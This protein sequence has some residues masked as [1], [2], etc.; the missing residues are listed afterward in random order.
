LP[1]YPPSIPDSNETK[2]ASISLQVALI[3]SFVTLTCVIVMAALAFPYILKIYR[4]S[5]NW[6][7]D[8]QSKRSSKRSEK[9][10][11]LKSVI[12]SSAST[13]ATSPTSSET[14]FHFPIIA[15]PPVSPVESA[16]HVPSAHIHFAKHGE[17]P[18]QQQQQQQQIPSS[19]TPIVTLPILNTHNHH[20]HH[21][22]ISLQSHRPK[23][24]KAI[25]PYH[26]NLD[27][28][29]QLKRGDLLI[30]N[31]VFS[32]G[33]VVGVNVV[34]GAEGTFPVACVAPLE[35]Y[36]LDPEEQELLSGR[37][38]FPLQPSQR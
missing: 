21:Q 6:N 3:I 23:L 5:L 24:H 38:T 1:I 36:G 10:D 2:G 30:I 18:A 28:E 9:P 13:P 8:Q 34:T 33:W 17:P 11:E 37:V 29:L 14:T 7:E 4:A 12:S 35:E 25:H 22:P 19:L 16:Y 27:D 31:E 26:P 32:D 20:H 15:T